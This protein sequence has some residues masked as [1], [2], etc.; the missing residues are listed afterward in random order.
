[1]QNQTAIFAN[2]FLAELLESL[3]DFSWMMLFI[4]VA[5]DTANVYATIHTLLIRRYLA[6]SQRITG[7]KR[8][9]L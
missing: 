4:P 6:G 3:F 5:S 1:M 9:M 2:Y 8:T 7:G